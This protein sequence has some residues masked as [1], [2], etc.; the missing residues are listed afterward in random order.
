MESPH[1]STKENVQKVEFVV[2]EIKLK[3]TIHKDI[4]MYNLW[5]HCHL[6]ELEC[7]VFPTS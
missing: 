1:L 7:L 2:F 6:A 3:T 4:I 5:D